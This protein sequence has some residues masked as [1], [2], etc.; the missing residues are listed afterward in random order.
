MTRSISSVL[1]EAAKQRRVPTNISHAF[2]YADDDMAAFCFAIDIRWDGL[3]SQL[4]NAERSAFLYLC[5]L[6]AEDEE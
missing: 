1:R 3:F 6:I 2:G 5:S 4:T